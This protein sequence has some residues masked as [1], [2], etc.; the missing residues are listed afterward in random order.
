MEGPLSLKTDVYGHF[1]RLMR[2]TGLGG[3]SIR[4]DSR[5]PGVTRGIHTKA[6][7]DV[8]SAS[9][10]ARWS[11]PIKMVQVGSCWRTGERSGTHPAA[12]RH[13]FSVQAR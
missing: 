8:D 6:P 12:H 9:R 2:V 4:V 7:E 13:W 1:R 11:R 5:G 10:T 3:P